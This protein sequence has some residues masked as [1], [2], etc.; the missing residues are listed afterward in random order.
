MA[1]R[2]AGPAYWSRDILARSHYQRDL[3]DWLFIQIARVG[4]LRDGR[5][6]RYWPVRPWRI[7][8]YAYVA[9]FDVWRYGFG[10]G[11]LLFHFGWTGRGWRILDVSHNGVRVTEFL[12]ARQVDFGLDRLPPPLP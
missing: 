4:G 7:G 2:I 10:R 11:R 1:A 3:R 5:P 9:G 12:R 8:A 6:V